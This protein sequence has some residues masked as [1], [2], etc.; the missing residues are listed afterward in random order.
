[1]VC[2]VILACEIACSLEYFCRLFSL[3]RRMPPKKQVAGLQR[4]N[5]EWVSYSLKFCPLSP[6]WAEAEAIQH[7]HGWGVRPNLHALRRMAIQAD[8]GSVRL[9]L[10]LRGQ[11]FEK[12]EQ[13]L[14]S[15]DKVAQRAKEAAQRATA[16]ICSSFLPRSQRA[17]DLIDDPVSDTDS[18]DEDA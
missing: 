8:V 13:I 14:A 16:S 2:I 15:N 5:G 12:E 17:Q 10:S 18:S 6:D 11:D 1:M 9:L 4:V 3:K 7:P